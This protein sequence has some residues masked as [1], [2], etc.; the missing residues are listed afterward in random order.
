MEEYFH[1]KKFPKRKK[2]IYLYR[3]RRITTTIKNQENVNEI[4]S[5]NYQT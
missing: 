2:I 5:C 3:N 4:N 1:V